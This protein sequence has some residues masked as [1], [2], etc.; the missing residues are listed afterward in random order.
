MRA[1]Q[2]HR[3]RPTPRSRSAKRPNRSAPAVIREVGKLSAPVGRGRRSASNPAAPRAW[4]WWCARARSATS[5]PAARWMPS[6]SGW[7]CRPRMPMAASSSGA[8]TSTDDGKGPVEPGAHFYRSYQLDGDGNPINKRNA[9]Q[10]RSLLYVRLIPPGAADV[11]H[12]LREGAATMPRARFSFTAKLNYRKFSWYYTQ[13]AYAGAAQAGTGPGAARRTTT[14]AWN[15]VSDPRRFRRMSPARFA[16]AFPIC[17]SSP[18]R[19]AHATMPL[20]TARLDAGGAQAGSRALE[21]LGHRPAAAGRS[22]RRRVRLPATSPKPSPGTPT[23]GS[24]WR[25]R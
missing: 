17:P 20:G 15:T 16:T 4:T 2:R 9:W 8:A 1:P 5:S 23:A 24:T 25:A 21:R 13:F 18:W 12:Y 10:A 3:R 14:T 7:S 6:T 19:E 11:A 22:E